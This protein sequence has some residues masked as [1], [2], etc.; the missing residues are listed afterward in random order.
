VLLLKICANVSM[1]SSR[2]WSRE[3]ND[4]IFADF[5]SC[6]VFEPLGRV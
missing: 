4:W 3:H 1:F 2:Q 6:S 5:L